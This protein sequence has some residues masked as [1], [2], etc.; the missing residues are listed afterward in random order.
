MVVF[1]NYLSEEKRRGYLRDAMRDQL[2][3]AFEH[4]VDQ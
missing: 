3:T 1:Q 4:G 2:E